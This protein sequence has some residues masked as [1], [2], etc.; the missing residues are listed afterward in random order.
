MPKIGPLYS[1][2]NGIWQNLFPSKKFSLA[3]A[4]AHV[5]TVVI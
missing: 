1:I 2:L 4:L 3:K 5:A